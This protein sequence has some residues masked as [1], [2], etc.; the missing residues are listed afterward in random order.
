MSKGHQISAGFRRQVEDQAS[1]IEQEAAATEIYS[2]HA[3]RRIR[4]DSR[5]LVVLRRDMDTVASMGN[6]GEGD[7]RAFL[8][9]IVAPYKHRTDSWLKSEEGRLVT[10]H[11]LPVGLRMDAVA[12]GS[13][14]GWAFPYALT[15]IRGQVLTQPL[16][17]LTAEKHFNVNGETANGMEQFDTRRANLQGMAKFEGSQVYDTAN[18]SVNQVELI[19]NVRYCSAGYRIGMRELASA[20]AGNFLLQQNLTKAAL[21]AIQNLA[22]QTV[23]RGNKQEQIWGVVDNHPLMPK[24]YLSAWT[25]A[26]Y[27][28]SNA[29]ANTWFYQLCKAVD[30]ILDDNFNTFRPD[31]VSV[32]SKIRT[33]ASRLWITIGGS[34]V[35]KTVWEA[36][37]EHL[38][39]NYGIKRDAVMDA[40]ELQNILLPDG[41]TVAQGLFIH[42]QNDDGGV[43]AQ[44]I[45]VPGPVALPVQ[46]VD[47]NMQQLW[48]QGIGGFRSEN[49]GACNMVFIPVTP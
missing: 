13:Y 41:T 9:K 35:S 15:Q 32:S 44:I 24:T 1:L 43:N 22:N 11:A 18:A 39:M 38:E 37:L 29:I 19:S 16:P 17:P 42:N 7:T 34:A 3:G 36:F 26:A 23:W 33:F 6:I 4:I 25:Q 28:A 47:L 12:G 27:T 48:Y 46:F 40:Q 5:P 20:E 14:G 10:Q 31:H 49:P 45:K 21:R 2:E 8:S 30:D